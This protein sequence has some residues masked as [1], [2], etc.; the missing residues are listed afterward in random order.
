[1]AP[2]AYV[3]PA[4]NGSAPGIAVLNGGGFVLA[5]VRNTNDGEVVLKRFDD[6]GVDI[7]FTGGTVDEVLVAG[8]NA[9]GIELTAT[10]SGGFAMAYITFDVDVDFNDV[11]HERH[12]AQYDNDAGVVGTPFSAA[13]IRTNSYMGLRNLADGKLLWIFKQGVVT[14]ANPDGED[15][16]QAGVYD[17]TGAELVLHELGGS[18]IADVMTA[19][20]SNGHVIVAY[21]LASPDAFAYATFDDEGNLIAGPF[22]PSEEECDEISVGVFGDGDFVIAMVVYDSSNG[23][24][25]N[26]SN[27]GQLLHIDPIFF[28]HG[29]LPDD[30]WPM[31]TAGDH[32]VAMAYDVSSSPN[33]YFLKVSKGYLPLK[34]ISE[35]EVRVTNWAADPVVVNIMTVGDPQ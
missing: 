26:V 3:D 18:I 17:N 4:A 10:E 8:N 13:I 2:F 22:T 19:R 30:R 33:N 5:F 35:N 29:W 12:L 11:N 16:I 7:G 6:A 1:V 28:G 21:E 34:V 23:L 24:M 27:N 31:F 14:P 25:W 20:A 9:F 15:R 32:E